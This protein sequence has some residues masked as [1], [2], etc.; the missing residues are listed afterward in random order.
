VRRVSPA[1]R[2]K[3]GGRHLFLSHVLAAEDVAFTAVDDGVWIVR[4]AALPLALFHERT[5][6]LESPERT[7]PPQPPRV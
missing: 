3:W 6:R 5:W 2:V 1:G 7:P 4:F